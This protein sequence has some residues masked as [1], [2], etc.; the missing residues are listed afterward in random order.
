MRSRPL[1][2]FEVNQV[3]NRIS[4][5][6]GLLTKEEVQLTC[7][8]IRDFQLLRQSAQEL[9]GLDPEGI[10]QR[11]PRRQEWGEII[12]RGYQQVVLLLASGTVASDLSPW[13]LQVATVAAGIFGCRQI[14]S[15]LGENRYRA[16]NSKYGPLSTVVGAISAL[17][18]DAKAEEERRFEEAALRYQ[19]QYRT[20]VTT[21]SSS[22]GNLKSR[23]IDVRTSMV[24]M[25]PSEKTITIN[26]SIDAL[27]DAIEEICLV[28][29]LTEEE[30]SV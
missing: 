19:E 27:K 10:S 24:H 4:R 7:S 17:F 21:H 12:T 20:F 25:K 30:I 5:Q 6:G 13:P 28:I 14:G 23:L 1:Y 11:Q 26:F 2:A 3:V 9:R 16:L 8:L 15:S 29:Q 22:Y 18:G